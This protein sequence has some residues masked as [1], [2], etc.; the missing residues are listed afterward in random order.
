[1]ILWSIKLISTL[2]RAIAG[3]KYPNQLAWAVAFGL[4]LGIIPHGN[5]L[6]IV[7]MIV[8]LSL[9]LNHAAA[10]LTA[11]GVSFLAAS[12]DPVSHRVGEY[13]LT[14]PRCADFA[15][16]AWAL[17]MVPWTDLNN[18]I[19]L[20]SFLIGSAA[21]LP[22]FAITY[23]I[24]RV[25][26]PRDEP[27]V[28]K[29]RVTVAVSAS[30]ET[31][32]VAI[33]DRRHT[34]VPSPKIAERPVRSTASVESASQS[35][36]DERIEFHEISDRSVV[37]TTEKQ[38]AVETRIDVI[39][40]KESSSQISAMANDKTASDHSGKKSSGGKPDDAKPMDEALNYLLRQLRDS[41]Q[42]NA[43]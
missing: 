1:M 13:V 16:N 18:T 3:R 15:Q 20:G 31:H 14:D 21:L 24:F 9:K 23:P 17:P 41:Q 25:F 19:V 5:L 26:R 38:V 10:G 8:V 12:L 35:Q 22:V 30:E 6:A 27:T 39:R 40:V 42:R 36:S 43:A 33:I 32:P 2:R 7:L 4:L 37:T 29:E 34:S 11:I 28:V